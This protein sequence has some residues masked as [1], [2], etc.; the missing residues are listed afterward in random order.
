MQRK[1]QRD[2]GAALRLLLD[3]LCGHARSLAPRP[4]AAGAVDSLLDALDAVAR[5]ARWIVDAPPSEDVLA[6]ATKFLEMTAITVAG[7][8]LAPQ[9]G[10]SIEH[11]SAPV[12]KAA[13]GRFAFFATERLA[14]VPS[15]LSAVTAGGERLAAAHL[16]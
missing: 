10:W 8:L 7:G 16:A 12:A 6:G 13:L 2:G 3:D 1:G 4:E 14:L 15:M 9:V 11:E 5:G